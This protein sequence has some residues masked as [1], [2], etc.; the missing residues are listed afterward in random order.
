MKF[1]SVFFDHENRTFTILDG[2]KGEYKVD[3]ILRYGI[4]NEKAKYKGKGVPFTA[5][6]PR[7]PGAPGLFY[8]QLY[9]GLKITLKDE[10]VLAIYV[11]QE[12]TQV[13]TDQYVR[14]D[15]EAKEIYN[16]IKEL[17]ETNK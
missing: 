13:G 15:K 12:Q 17:L 5:V 3:D 10:S 14:D 16:N 9:V 1:K 7:G 8:S 4:F 11:S 6:I 2:T